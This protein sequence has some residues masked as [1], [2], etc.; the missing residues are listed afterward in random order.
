MLSKIFL[1]LKQSQA[2]ALIVQ[3]TLL[4]VDDSAERHF[5]LV[6]AFQPHFLQRQIHELFILKFIRKLSEG[7]N[8]LHF[9][10]TTTKELSSAEST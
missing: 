7:E 2:Q 4:H 9:P 5:R 1:Y 10:G 6:T 8:E 3:S